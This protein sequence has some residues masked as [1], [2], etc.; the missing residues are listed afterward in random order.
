MGGKMSRSANRGAIQR[1]LKL[2]LEA[3]TV[4]TPGQGG[5]SVSF[6][7]SGLSID[8]VFQAWSAMA[9]LIASNVPLQAGG[10]AGLVYAV[11]MSAGWR[12]GQQET[13]PV[14][15]P[16]VVDAA[17]E[18][19]PLP[20]LPEGTGDVLEPAAAP[21]EPSAEPNAED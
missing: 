21:A 17:P 19:L 12:P 18:Q 11:A 14:D 1:N 9:Q 13:A 7:I 4:L 15:A 6:N 8:E 5:P 20:G 2:T 3:Q 10:P 16:T